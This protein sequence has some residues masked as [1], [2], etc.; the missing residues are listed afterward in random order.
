MKTPSEVEG[1]GTER[2][3]KVFDALDLPGGA[4]EEAGGNQRGWLKFH[5][6]YFLIFFI[7]VLNSTLG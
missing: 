5:L 3:H 6:F 1:A 7:F 4:W 2:H